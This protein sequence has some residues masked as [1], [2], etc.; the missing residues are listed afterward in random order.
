MPFIK[1]DDFFSLRSVHGL[2]EKGW[3][4]GKLLEETGAGRLAE[5]GNPGYQ[6]LVLARLFRIGETSDDF[7]VDCTVEGFE[8]AF[9]HSF[10]VVFA[11]GFN[12]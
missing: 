3:D 6:I 9:K 1:T 4:K 7:A 5:F 10:Y 8:F 2:K 12:N 11:H